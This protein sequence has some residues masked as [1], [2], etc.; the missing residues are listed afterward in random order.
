LLRYIKNIISVSLHPVWT[1]GAVVLFVIGLYLGKAIM[2]MAL[3]YMA[4]N[5]V[6]SGQLLSYFNKAI[7]LGLARAFL[8]IPLISIVGLTYTA[9]LANGF[10]K[11]QMQM[12]FIVLPLFI[13][14]HYN[15]LKQYWLHLLQALVLL[16]LIGCLYSLGKYVMDKS[17][18]DTGYH[19]GHAIPTPFKNDHIRF[20]LVVSACIFITFYYW[21]Q[22]PFLS[23]KWV[24]YFLIIFLVITLHIISAR[25]GL[26]ALYLGAF[27]IIVY[28]IVTQKQYLWGTLLLVI[29]LAL[30]VMAYYISP[31]FKSKID[32]TQYSWQQ[33]NNSSN[34][35]FIS[36]EG[37]MI[38]YKL[39]WHIITSNLIIGVGT[40]DMESNMMKEYHNT[41]GTQ[42]NESKLLDPHNQLLI[43][44]VMHGIMGLLLFVHLIY[45]TTLVPLFKNKIPSFII[46]LGLLIGLMVEPM[47][48]TQYGIAVFLLL[49]I[50]SQWQA[51]L[52]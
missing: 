12:P 18:I 31:T 36:D 11:I 46:S 47:L 10:S 24:Q 41:L 28:Y 23:S 33:L 5:I 49:S 32:Y 9:Q 52:E 22:M 40:G 2:S 3:L 34:Q 35:T 8:L 30:P 43:A 26:L 44:M 20:S 7:K 17:I 45:H 27:V 39:A 19:I 51:Q 29:M 50:L 6:V 21:Q 4:Y 16:T 1:I 42:L 48:L 15:H 25:T 13:V 14:G 38:S 37:R